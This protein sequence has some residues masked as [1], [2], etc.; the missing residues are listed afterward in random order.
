ML[1]GHVFMFELV[2][3]S[4][5]FKGMLVLL[6]FE[7][8][9]VSRLFCFCSL[10]IDSAIDLFSV[11]GFGIVMFLVWIVFMIFLFVRVSTV[12]MGGFVS[13]LLLDMFVSTVSIMA[14]VL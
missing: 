9:D 11:I 7:I 8:V 1:V 2:L 14:I 12:S 4:D 13:V 10:P 6:V 5:G 3:S